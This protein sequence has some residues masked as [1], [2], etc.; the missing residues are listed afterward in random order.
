MAPFWFSSLISWLSVFVDGA[1]YVVAASAASIP[2]CLALEAHTF[3]L[4]SS[5]G[6]RTRSCS[7]QKSSPA[8][9][10]GPSLF[11]LLHVKAVMTLIDSVVIY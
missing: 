10:A 8:R 4:I 6:A 3:A 2:F 11:T 5:V 9:L 7:T 1:L